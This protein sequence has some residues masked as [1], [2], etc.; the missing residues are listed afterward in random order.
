MP[1]PNCCAPL[2]DPEAK[3]YSIRDLSIAAGENKA[4]GKMDL[5]LST[6]LPLLSASL[7]SQ[8]LALGPLNLAFEIVGPV[9]KP[10]LRKLNLHIG[11]EKLAEVKLKGTVKD[12][13]GLQGV[14]LKFGVRG[15]DLASL[16]ELTGHP[17]PLKGPFSASG[18][19][20]MPDPKSLAI[21]KLQITA[22]KNKIGGS[23][24]LD[25]RGNKPR[26]NATLSTQDLVAASVLNPKI[27]G[28]LWVT[29]I[30][31]LAPVQLSIRL[32]GLA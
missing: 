5:N 9:D 8:E 22:G 19:V 24:E 25:L 27:A 30:D 7:A 17:L 10:A 4:T 31:Q 3:I 26:L 29:A 21:S 12:L 28:D 2:Q 18:D 6:G 16:Q 20:T 15:Q 23:A 13:R 11:S 1:L 14:D 32:E